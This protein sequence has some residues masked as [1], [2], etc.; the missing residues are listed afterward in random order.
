MRY[1]KD[2][3]DWVRLQRIK[4]YQ[5]YDQYWNAWNEL[6]EKWIEYFTNVFLN[7]KCCAICGLTKLDHQHEHFKKLNSMYNKLNTSELQCTPY[8]IVNCLLFNYM[9]TSNGKEM[10]LCLKCYVEWDMST[11]AKYVVFQ[12]PNQYMKTLL[13]KHP[14]YVQC[15]F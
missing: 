12:S 5:P 7:M 1:K 6:Y 10:Y 4:H 11:F 14:L 8:G 9:M 15:F 2:V 3:Y 13:S